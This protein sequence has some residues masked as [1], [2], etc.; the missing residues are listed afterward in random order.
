MVNKNNFK[1]EVDISLWLLTDWL[2]EQPSNQPTNQP[3]I[4]HSWETHT[5][6]VKKTSKFYGTRRV[7]TTFTNV[8][9][10]SLAAL[11]YATQ[12]F[13]RLQNEDTVQT[14]GITCNMQYF[15]PNEMAGR[16]KTLY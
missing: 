15:V 10:W 6:L 11:E 5:Q 7:I 3:Q 2:T 4:A 9:H 12:I 1:I 16:I 13:Y 14:S 8:H